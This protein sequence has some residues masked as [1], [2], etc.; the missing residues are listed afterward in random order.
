MSNFYF[1][2]WFLK[3]PFR[4]LVDQHKETP[5]TREVLKQLFLMAFP[6]FAIGVVIPIV[7]L[8]QEEISIFTAIVACLA[9]FILS[10]WLLNYFFLRTT[11]LYTCGK[12]IQGKV[13]DAKY[14][15][16]YPLSGADTYGYQIKWSFNIFDREYTGKLPFY[17]VKDEW[18]ANLYV[19]RPVDIYYA[20]DRPS[21]SIILAPDLY[22]TFCLK[23]K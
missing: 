18:L 4:A 23:D 8:G 1:V 19:G 3:K 20:P 6:L 14:I 22:E 10:V 5:K 11:F 13:T 9:L 2:R 15:E 16:K 17:V 12:K 7:L 21:V